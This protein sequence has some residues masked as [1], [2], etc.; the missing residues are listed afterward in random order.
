ML[1]LSRKKME[2]VMIGGN[3]VVTVLEIRGEKVRLDIEAP[4]D[5]EILREELLPKKEAA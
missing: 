2:R 3:I 1:V 5:V 4:A